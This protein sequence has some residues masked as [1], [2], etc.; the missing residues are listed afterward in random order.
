[1]NVINKTTYAIND[2]WLDLYK[3]FVLFELSDNYYLDL[4]YWSTVCEQDIGE[5]PVRDYALQLNKRI[6]SGVIDHSGS[7]W[8][9]NQSFDHNLKVRSEIRYWI[10]PAHVMWWAKI[11]FPFF[12]FYR[13]YIIVPLINALQRARVSVL[14]LL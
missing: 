13:K 6:C 3:A 10:W 5:L 7:T 12:F 2:I 1:V 11:N 14:E 8:D 9:G 4:A